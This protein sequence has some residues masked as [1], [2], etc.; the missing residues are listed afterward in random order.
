MPNRVESLLEINETSEYLTVFLCGVHVCLLK[1]EG[2]IHM[3]G[4]DLVCVVTFR[5]GCLCF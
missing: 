3:V 1:C 2:Y 5:I 4:G